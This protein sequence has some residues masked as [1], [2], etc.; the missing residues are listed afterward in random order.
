MYKQERKA[1]WGQY[2]VCLAA[3]LI[4]WILCDILAVF[5]KSAI[6]ADF[7]FII[8][9]CIMV[10]LVYSHYCAVFTYEI[11]KK[12]LIITRKTGHRELK[13]EITISKI[14]YVGTKK[15]PKTYHKLLKFTVN[16]FLKKNYCYIVYDS[17]TKCIVTEADQELQK[18]IKENTDG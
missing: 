16:V 2:L 17:N 9:A 12:K 7:I 10:Y 4:L 14:N 5:L 18:L 6:A 1:G 8:T 3:G 11:K 13:E 15:P